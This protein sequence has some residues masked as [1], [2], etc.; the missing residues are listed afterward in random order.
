MK[1]ILLGA[2]MLLPLLQHKEGSKARAFSESDR[3][4]RRF[5]EMNN[6]VSF[7]DTVI[8]LRKIFLKE[9]LSF[10][11]IRKSQIYAGMK[12]PIQQT[13][14]V[15]NLIGKKIVLSLEIR[16]LK[17]SIRKDFFKNWQLIMTDALARNLMTSKVI[18]PAG[19]KWLEDDVV[20]GIGVGFSSLNNKA[21]NSIRQEYQNNEVFK[22]QFRAALYDILAHELYHVVDPRKYKGEF[23][24]DSISSIGDAVEDGLGTDYHD[25]ENER[26]TW[27]NDLVDEFWSLYDTY[28]TDQERNSLVVDIIKDPHAFWKSPHALFMGASDIKEG[29]L[30]ANVTYAIYTSL[31]ESGVPVEE[32][33][34]KHFK[35]PPF[36]ERWQKMFG[37]KK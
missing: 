6:G 20:K 14:S 25:A 19:W 37:T 26:A 21:W 29:P 12:L 36:E 23:S 9:F 16:F 31:K 4:K 8:A 32:I 10:T 17:N 3:F 13:F 27:T 22:D 35:L 1:G 2:A 5:E 24:L 34:R 30:L 33:R 15:H 28:E 7:H 18:M 11:W